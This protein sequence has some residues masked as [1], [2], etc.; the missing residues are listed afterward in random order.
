V[1]L[2]V[3]VAGGS[4]ETSAVEKALRQLMDLLWR[5]ISEDPALVDW[6]RSKLA[7]L[8]QKHA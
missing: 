4:V 2:A 7:E 8:L 5:R 6:V 3:E 1:D